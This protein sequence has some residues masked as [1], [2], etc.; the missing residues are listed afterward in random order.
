MARVTRRGSSGSSQFFGVTV[1]QTFTPEKNIVQ[2]IRRMNTLM[3]QRTLRA[4]QLTANLVQN[5]MRREAEWEDQPDTYQGLISSYY[6][7]VARPDSRNYTGRSTDRKKVTEVR[8]A[9]PHKPPRYP[10]PHAREGLYAR[11]TQVGDIFTIEA[12]ISQDVF[13]TAGRGFYYGLI[14]EENFPIVQPTMNN[15][16]VQTLIRALSGGGRALGFSGKLRGFER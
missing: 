7:D 2:N 1:S 6:V 12:G 16:G 14:L 13:N 4:A 3:N 9:H 11:V 8:S 15:E 5:K 10:G